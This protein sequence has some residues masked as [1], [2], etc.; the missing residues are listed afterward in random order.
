MEGVVSV[1]L[2]LAE[3]PCP[4]DEDAMRER[5]AMRAAFLKVA[6]TKNYPPYIIGTLNDKVEQEVAFFAVDQTDR[7]FIVYTVTFKAAERRC[8]KKIEVLV[9]P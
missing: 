6:S 2:M 8:V 3:A 5:D 7:G 4:D 9:R 1:H